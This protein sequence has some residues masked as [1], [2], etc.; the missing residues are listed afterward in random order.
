MSEPQITHVYLTRRNLRALLRKLDVQKLGVPSACT[1]VKGD[2]EH[3]R[4]PLRNADYCIV[5]AV[6]DEDY[7]TDRAPG[8]MREDLE[9]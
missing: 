1:I 5:T 8:A 6:E 7:Y 4:Y 9:T 2:T 3:D